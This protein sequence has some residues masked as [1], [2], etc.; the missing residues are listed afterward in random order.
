MTIRQNS[1]RRLGFL[2][3]RPVSVNSVKCQPS[4][5]CVLV[6]TDSRFAVMATK[7]HLTSRKTEWPPGSKGAARFPVNPSGG[8]SS[9]R[10]N[11]WYNLLGED[12]Y[13]HH[14][15]QHSLR[16]KQCRATCVMSGPASTVSE[17]RPLTNESRHALCPG[18]VAAGAAMKNA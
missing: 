2:S 13:H 9:L 6:P 10:M 1:L 12:Y 17:W 7:S 14:L 3:S 11:I 18:C 4:S 15:H 16:C 8:G 5:A